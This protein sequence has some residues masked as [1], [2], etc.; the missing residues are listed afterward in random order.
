MA[1]PVKFTFD[2]SFGT[3]RMKAQP[4]VETPPPAPAEPPPP[5]PPTFSEEELAAARAQAQAEGQAAGRGEVMASVE[6]STAELL[7]IAARLGEL[8]KT[9]EAARE[10]V[11]AEAAK[12]ALAIGRRLARNLLAREPEVEVEAM[13]SACLGDLG[14][15]P[16][17]VVRVPEAL[18]EAMSEKVNGLAA[19]AGFNGQVMLLGDAALGPADCRIEWTDGGAS[20]NQEEI[21]AQVEAAI[22]RYAA[23]APGAPA[24]A[25]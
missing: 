7:G 18:V 16:R 13:I 21:D 5:P 17:I 24:A 4:K 22:E 3:R 10:Q 25:D 8:G 20:R 19:R 9:E 14:G 23:A 1:Q 15:E 12:L 6:K 2:T 11:R